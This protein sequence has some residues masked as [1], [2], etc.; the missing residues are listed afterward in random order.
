MYAISDNIDG[1]PIFWKRCTLFYTFT[2][3]F[4]MFILSVAP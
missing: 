3:D 1:A 4:G 2:N